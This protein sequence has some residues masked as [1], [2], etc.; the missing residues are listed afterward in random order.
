MP[1]PKRIL[2]SKVF[3]VLGAI[4]ASGASIMS[5]VSLSDNLW[6]RLFVS[7]SIF[8]LI[9]AGTIEAIRFAG[10]TQTLDPNTN[11][12]AQDTK[13]D[14]SF[15]ST[16]PNTELKN[17]VTKFVISLHD[18]DQRMKR[19]KPPDLFLQK[20]EDLQAAKTEEEKRKV[21]QRYFER[22]QQASKE[23]SAQ[24]KDEYNRDY[25]TKAKTLREE[26]IR[27]IP[28]DNLGQRRTLIYENLAGPEPIREIAYDLES[29]SNL[30]PN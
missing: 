18:F 25:Y 8:G 11:A 12:K 20:G 3:F 5:L 6:V 22:E 1:N 28:P 10:H 27:H 9:G 17:E 29:L 16:P 13:P 4:T 30:L 24:L 2:A 15:V 26:M 7:F 19:L 21:L 23:W 14:T